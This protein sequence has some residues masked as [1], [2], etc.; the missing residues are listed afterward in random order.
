MPSN[1][2]F[3]LTFPQCGGS[4]RF[5]TDPDHTFYVDS[6]QEPDPKFTLLVKHLLKKSKNL[7]ICFPKSYKTCYV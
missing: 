4:V 5:G 3:S 1:Y 2:K 7:Q 6:D